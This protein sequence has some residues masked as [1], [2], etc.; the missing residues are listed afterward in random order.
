M[1][2]L[3]RLQIVLNHIMLTL[4][5]YFSLIEA[6]F[7]ICIKHKYKDK[8]EANPVSNEV[9]SDLTRTPHGE[10][11]VQAWCLRFLVT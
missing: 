4:S 6:P 9:D 5:S 7:K 11:R 10:L 3:Q 1:E 8:L 2:A